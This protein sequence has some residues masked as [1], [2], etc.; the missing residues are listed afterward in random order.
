MSAMLIA[1]AVSARQY[2]NSLSTMFILSALFGTISGFLGNYFSVEMTHY[3]KQT[4]P[5]LRLTLPTGPMIVIVASALCLFS[6][7]FAPERGLLLRLFRIAFFRYQC[8]YENLLKS[9]WRKGSSNVLSFEQIRSFQT[10]SPIYLRF[11]LWRLIHSG[12]IKKVGPNLYQLTSDGEQCAAK[13]IRLHRL[14]EVYLADYVGIGPERV[15]RSAEEMEHI[16]T[17]ELE[18]ELTLLLHDPKQ[19]PHHQPIPPR[20]QL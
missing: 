4:Y 15:H 17:P 8:A 5:H 9:L 14:W 16:I 18:E 1:P 10:V 6:L 2:T 7:L 3:L 19:D 20:I 11:I 13:I 12:W